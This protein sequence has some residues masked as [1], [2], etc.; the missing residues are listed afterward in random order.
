MSRHFNYELDERRIKI[1]LKENSMPYSDDV[2]NEFVAKTKPLAK[3]SK[4]PNFKP[5]VSFEINKSV[6]L[7]GVFVILIGSFTLLIAKFVDFK[8]SG[9]NLESVREVKP[10][11]SNYKIEKPVVAVQ[12]KKEEPKPQPIIKDTVTVAPTPS[13]APVTN[14]QVAIAETKPSTPPVTT[15]TS[16]KQNESD[17]VAKSSEN[18]RSSNV[19]QSDNKPRKKKKR[20]VET[21]EAKPMT[22][23]LPTS[24]TEE[25]ELELK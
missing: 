18:S 19:A 23:A 11:P 8:S 5:N 22:T 9:A 24:N 6:V 16:S 4:L 12:V 17:S 15:E 2:W 7:T 3:A 14:T 20:Q 21:L 25:P 1:L 13:V 10:D